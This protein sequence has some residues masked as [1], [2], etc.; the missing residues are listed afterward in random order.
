[1]LYPSQVVVHGDGNIDVIVEGGQLADIEELKRVGFHNTGLTPV[2][3]SATALKGKIELYV[4]DL[5]YES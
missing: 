5:L 1:M 2:S 3:Q 4:S